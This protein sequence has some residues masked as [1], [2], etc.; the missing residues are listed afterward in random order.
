MKENAN[1]NPSESMRIPASLQRKTKEPIRMVTFKI[2][3]S[4]WEELSALARDYDRD[5]ST[6][7]REATEDWLVRARQVRKAN[8]PIESEGDRLVDL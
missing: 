2:P 4:W 6:F 5:V 8:P 1:D 3:H 7:L